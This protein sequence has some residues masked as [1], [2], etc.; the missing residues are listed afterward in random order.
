MD[1]PIE[2]MGWAGQSISI[3]LMSQIDRL[4][5]G[6]PIKVPFFGW[7]DWLWSADTIEAMG[8]QA[9]GRWAPAYLYMRFPP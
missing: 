3:K 4:A 2:V 9:Q 5:Q 1:W 8:W 6:L 7:L